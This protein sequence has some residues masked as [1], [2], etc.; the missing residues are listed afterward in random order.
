MLKAARIYDAEINDSFG[1]FAK[2]VISNA[3]CDLKR[4]GESSYD[5]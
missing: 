5:Y 2:T 4:N 1:G 3:M